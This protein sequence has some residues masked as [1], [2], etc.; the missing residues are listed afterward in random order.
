M[1]RYDLIIL[2]FGLFELLVNI[3]F[4]LLPILNFGVSSIPMNLLSYLNSAMP[5]SDKLV[6]LLSQ[7]KST[8]L[9]ADSWPLTAEC[10]HFIFYYLEMSDSLKIFPCFLLHIAKIKEY[11]PTAQLNL[12]KLNQKPESIVKRKSVKHYRVKRQTLY[13][14]KTSGITFLT[15]LTY[16]RRCA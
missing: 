10:L 9:M 2:Y 16:S 14:P 1:G 13:S 15:I 11:K 5:N 12:F 6:K 3:N 7:T 4:S 8:L